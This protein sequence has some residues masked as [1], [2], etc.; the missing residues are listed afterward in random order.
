MAGYRMMVLLLFAFIIPTMFFISG[1]VSLYSHDTLV[2]SIFGKREECVNKPGSSRSVGG[3]VLESIE[4]QV[5]Q[6]YSERDPAGQAVLKK[7]SQSH[8]NG[9]R[10]SIQ[11]SFWTFAS[12]FIG[13]STV[14][15]T[16]LR[17][18]LASGQLGNSKLLAL[19]LCWS[20]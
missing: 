10:A 3:E 16:Y 15:L 6:G 1:L 11:Y 13:F 17:P 20:S 19:Q 7:N 8:Q 4:D 18:G 2:V 14:L 5:M 12:V 9:D